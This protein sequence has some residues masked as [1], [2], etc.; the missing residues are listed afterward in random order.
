MEY[1]KNCMSC[2]KDTAYDPSVASEYIVWCLICPRLTLI[3]SSALTLSSYIFFMCSTNSHSLGRQTLVEHS[4]IPDGFHTTKWTSKVDTQDKGL[5]R[6]KR[7][8]RDVKQILQA[9][10]VHLRESNFLILWE[11]SRSKV[12]GALFLLQESRMHLWFAVVWFVVWITIR[13]SAGN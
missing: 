8:S 6:R 2:K 10:V 13:H 9:E 11:S 7:W 12:K 4:P 3:V 5:S 1:Q